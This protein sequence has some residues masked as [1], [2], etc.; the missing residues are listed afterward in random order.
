[1]QYQEIVLPISGLQVQWRDDEHFRIG[2][3][4]HRPGDAGPGAE[5]PWRPWVGSNDMAVGTSGPITGEEAA[6][7][8]AV[9][10]QYTGVDVEVSVDGLADPAIM[11]FHKLWLTEWRGPQRE[12][13]V[14]SADQQAEI[15]FAAPVAVPAERGSVRWRNVEA[16][17]GFH[18]APARA[19][20]TGDVRVH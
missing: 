9:W 2:A 6:R 5:L 1:M 8:W 14:V 17:N 10:G 13:I 11:I 3:P 20:R 15:E 12:A 19:Q 16:P 18:A 7:W 4:G